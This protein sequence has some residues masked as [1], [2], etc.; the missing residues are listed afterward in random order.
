M[1]TVFLSD[2]ARISG[3]TRDAIRN[4]QNRDGTPWDDDEFADQS[5]RRYGVKHALSLILCEFLESQRITATDAARFVKSQRSVV[6]RFL[7]DLAAGDATPRFVT[8]AY[9]GDEAEGR[10]IWTPIF[11]A[12]YGT[13]EEV[14]DLFAGELGRIGSEK[15]RNKFGDEITVRRVGGPIVAVASMQE[16]FRILK[17]RAAMAGFEPTGEGFKRIDGNPVAGDK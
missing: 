6:S 5:R 10:V 14:S 17:I 13:A 16:A 12:S 2:L 8:A 3:R 15:T 9:A 4:M 11:L 1:N 7:S